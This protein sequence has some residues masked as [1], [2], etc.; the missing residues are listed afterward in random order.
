[1]FQPV[2]KEISNIILEAKQK[3]PLR[4]GIDGLDAAGKTFLANQI[5]N[6]L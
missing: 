3:F 4:V 5:A 2:I 6:E 1:M